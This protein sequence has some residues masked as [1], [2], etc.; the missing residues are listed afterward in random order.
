MGMVAEPEEQ[1]TETSMVWGGSLENNKALRT[2]IV[3][4]GDYIYI[5]DLKKGVEMAGYS[6][7]TRK[8]YGVCDYF[9]ALSDG[10]VKVLSG[11]DLEAFLENYP[12][13]REKL[14]E[15]SSAASEFTT[16]YKKL[17]ES[18]G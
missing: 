15:S 4:K 5:K 6:K 7:R 18:G 1:E 10:L 9:A 2:K 11:D 17:M 3:R 13:A 8:M 14:P 16:R 12:G